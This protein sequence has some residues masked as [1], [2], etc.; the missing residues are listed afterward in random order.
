MLDCRANSADMHVPG[1]YDMH[2]N[3]FHVVEPTLT[4]VPAVNPDGDN[5]VRIN[6]LVWQLVNDAPERC[7]A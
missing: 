5:V 3:L 6:L 4:V 1:R 7:S 2:T